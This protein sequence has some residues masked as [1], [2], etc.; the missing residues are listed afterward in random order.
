MFFDRVDQLR[1][2]DWL[3]D[4][5]MSLKMKS[6]LCFTVRDQRRKENYRRVVQFPVGFNLCR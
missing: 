3:R 5:W 4:E 2:A 6:A 1:N